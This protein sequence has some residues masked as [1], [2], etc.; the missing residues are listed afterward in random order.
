[1]ASDHD[2]FADWLKTLAPDELA[3][4]KALH[5]ASAQ[6]AAD[7]AVQDDDVEDLDEADTAQ[8]SQTEADGEYLPME[9]QLI[10]MTAV[11]TAATHQQ[12]F[13]LLFFDP[14]EPTGRAFWSHSAS[15]EDPT[16][17]QA[18]PA[19]ALGEAAA[20]EAPPKVPQNW[21]PAQ[22]TFLPESA[23]AQS[24]DPTTKAMPQ[25][26]QSPPPKPKASEPQ[27]AQETSQALPIPKVATA[28][29]SPQ[30]SPEP[31]SSSSD[32][33]PHSALHGQTR[34]GVF[35]EPEFLASDHKPTYPG[36][37]RPPKPFGL[38]VIWDSRAWINFYG[39]EPPN[40]AV[41][42]DV[43]SHFYTVEPGPTEDQPSQPGPSQE[44]ESEPSG[45]PVDLPPCPPLP[46]WFSADTGVL[47]Y[48]HF[49]ATEKGNPRNMSKQS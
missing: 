39:S 14:E 41:E 5:S 12:P 35:F 48:W 42:I 32:Q 46:E 6:T 27:T 15:H 25:V 28:T 44:Q 11:V 24:A 33:A 20:A 30:P 47:R 29:P 3:K 31:A 23:K 49:G 13:P 10:D 26:Q 18:F 43:E 45:E 2:A 9:E 17:F 8:P 37:Y 7:T 1:M 38:A 40:A 21:K 19:A 22:Q 16:C 34:E 4:L 36:P